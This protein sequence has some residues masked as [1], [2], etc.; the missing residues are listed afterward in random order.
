MDLRG[1]L[2]KC[3]FTGF[4][5]LNVWF[6]SCTT[7]EEKHISKK[8]SQ[9]LGRYLF[10]DT[11]L[12]FNETKSCGSCHDPKFAFSDGYRKSITA[13]GDIALHNSPS[14]INVAYQSYFDWA[15][16]SITSLEKQADRPLFNQHPIELGVK[17]YENIILT[18]LQKDP[19]YKNQFLA[20]FGEKDA[21]SFTN[22][23]KA[24]AAFTSSLVSFNA[25]YDRYLKGD[26]LALSVSARQGMQLFLSEKLKCAKCHQPP[27]FFLNTKNT[28]SLYVNIGLYNVANNNSYPAND[29]GLRMV[30]QKQ[31][32]DG[33]F[34]IPSLRNIALTAPYT[35]D[36]SVNNLE[37]MISIYAA[38]G[39]NI[40]KNVFGSG[41]GC[42]NK[43][44][45][46]LIKGFTITA[47]EKKQLID[48][49]YA[50]TDSTVLT[51]PSFQ[52]PFL[53]K[54]N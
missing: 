41:N 38:G 37:E 14:L 8:S 46:A 52:N 34:K 50:L 30:T 45:S 16:P 51:N 10:F 23:K 24:L 19:Y 44:K 39:R 32:D 47:D 7:P 33:K 49:L 11:R 53:Q 28:D 42:A 21:F 27:T 36:G 15:D 4:V 18:R 9:E 13:T 35:H 5:L 31:T 29:A 17:G 54:R 6:F 12:S 48:F 43:N 25:P 26:S 3:F 40:S 20:C 22:I 1:G 2:V